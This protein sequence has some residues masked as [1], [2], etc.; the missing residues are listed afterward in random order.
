MAIQTK[1]GVRILAKLAG[2]VSLGV[3]ATMP[4][5]AQDASGASAPEGEIVVSGIRASLAQ[6]ADIKREAA[7]GM[8]VIT[9]EDAGKL[10]D[11]NVR[12]K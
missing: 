3:L 10:P 4:A 8:D 11:A 12:G 9:S 2:G 1:R 7:Q 5:Y 6:A